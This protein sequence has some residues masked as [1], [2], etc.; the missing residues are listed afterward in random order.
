MWCNM[1]FLVFITAIYKM[2]SQKVAFSC[3]EFYTWQLPWFYFKVIKIHGKYCWEGD[4]YFSLW[5]L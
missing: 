2:L 3:I 5:S 4:F 1:I